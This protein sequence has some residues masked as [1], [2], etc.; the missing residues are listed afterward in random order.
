M[1]CHRRLLEP[2]AR[3]N[4]I[5]VYVHETVAKTYYLPIINVI[6][7][8]LSKQLFKTVMSPQGVQEHRI[9]NIVGFKYLMVYQTSRLSAHETIKFHWQN[10][11]H[12]KAFVSKNLRAN[13]RIYILDVYKKFC[14]IQEIS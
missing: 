7:L 2:S 5:D 4:F 9:H 1:S 14:L 10:L 13:L 3:Q 12:R 8:P 6:Q 11:Q